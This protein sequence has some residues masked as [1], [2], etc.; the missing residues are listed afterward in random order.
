MM[1]VQA[2]KSSSGF[3]IA[4]LRRAYLKKCILR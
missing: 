1:L 3:R 2:I 4:P